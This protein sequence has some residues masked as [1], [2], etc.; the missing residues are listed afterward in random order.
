VVGRFLTEYNHCIPS[1]LQEIF[2][3]FLNF[4]KDRATPLTLLGSGAVAVAGVTNLVRIALFNTY[5]YMLGS[6]E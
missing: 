3:D 1:Y 5:K 2:Q 4:L 6:L